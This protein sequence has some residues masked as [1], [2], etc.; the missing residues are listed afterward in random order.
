M[1]IAK[2]TASNS[3]RIHSKVVYRS[4]TFTARVKQDTITTEDHTGIALRSKG[5]SQGLWD[6][7]LCSIKRMG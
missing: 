6:V 7:G 1:Q 2:C 3:G 5:K 4:H